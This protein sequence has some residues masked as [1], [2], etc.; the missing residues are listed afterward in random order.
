MK[1]SKRSWE[2][3]NKSVRMGPIESNEIPGSKFF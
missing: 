2:Q 1:K 3:S